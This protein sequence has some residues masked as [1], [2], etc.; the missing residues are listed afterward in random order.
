MAVG[1]LKVVFIPNRCCPL[2][3]MPTRA[4]ETHPYPVRAIFFCL[5]T[6]V[7]SERDYIVI[8]GTTEFHSIIPSIFAASRAEYLLV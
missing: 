8:H 5:L 1:A 3:L 7:F 2:P 6:L 4:A